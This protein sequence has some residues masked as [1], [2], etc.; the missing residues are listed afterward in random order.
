MS[1]GRYGANEGSRKVSLEITVDKWISDALDKIRTKRSVSN[2]VNGLLAIVIRQFDPGPS[3]PLIYAL[4]RLLTR[5]KERAEAAGDPEMVAS[6]AL[7][8]SR[9][10]PYF[11]LAEVIPERQNTPHGFRADEVRRDE[12][13]SANS[14]AIID[15]THSALPGEKECAKRDYQWYA[16]PTF[17]HGTPMTYLSNLNAWRCSGCGSLCPDS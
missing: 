5:Y 12:E 9:L 13:E 11:D 4:D 7:L 15:S 3:S 10:E 6:V 2:L 1:L 16:V 8:R 17:C 14:I